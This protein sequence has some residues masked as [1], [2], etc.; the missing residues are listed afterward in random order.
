[1]VLYV[2]TGAK[3]Y[4]EFFWLAAGDGALE[5]LKADIEATKPGAR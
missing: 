5:R 4:K 3:D 2:A 1:M